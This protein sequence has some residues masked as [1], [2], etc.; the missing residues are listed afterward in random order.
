MALRLLVFDRTCTWL[1]RAW[2][3]GAHLYR[4]LR[5][6]DA[7]RPVSSWDDA[8]GWLGTH[9]GDQPIGEIQYWGHGRWGHVLVESDVLDAARLRPTHASFSAIERVR[10]RLVPDARVWLRTCEAFG[11]DAGHD[12]AM[13][14]A[15]TL[16]V[17]VAGHTFVIGAVQSGLRTLVPGARP[18]WST[19]EGVCEGTPA[20]PIRA[21]GSSF[22][23][24]R[25]V[26]C[27]TG[28]FSDSWF[29]EDSGR[30]TTVATRQS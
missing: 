5:R 24:P 14:L 12:F 30:G 20:Q 11:A 28:S 17:R 4:G 13:R 2:G 22:S 16:G 1:S 15:D 9:A 7:A 29:D 23:R 27:F 21:H 18:T 8:L 6:I 19:S 26:T 3:T 25:T 10:E